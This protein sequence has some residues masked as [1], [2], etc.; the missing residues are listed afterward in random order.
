MGKDYRYYLDMGIYEFRRG[1]FATALENF[2]KSVELKSDFEISYFYRAAAHQALENF[3]EA[4]LDYSKAIQL[5]PNMTDAYYNK[6]K[7][8]LE[9][10]D[11]INPNLIDAVENLEKALSLDENFV[12]ALFAMAA[13]KKKLGQYEDALSYLDKILEL[14]PEAVHAKAFK[15]LILQK[16]M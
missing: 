16:Y 10:K 12:D 1:E 3:D 4:M 2:N 15:K 14:E 11:I 5:N 6:A 9:R 8:I 13:A 7:I